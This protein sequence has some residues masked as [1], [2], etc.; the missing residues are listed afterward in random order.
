VAHAS[1][2]REPLLVGDKDELVCMASSATASNP[3]A[4][5]QI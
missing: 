4:L 2:A 5:C 3:I 1:S